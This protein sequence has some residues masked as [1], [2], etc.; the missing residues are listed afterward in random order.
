V[1]S[2]LRLEFEVGFPADAEAA[3]DSEPQPPRQ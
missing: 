3:D 1:P 2:R